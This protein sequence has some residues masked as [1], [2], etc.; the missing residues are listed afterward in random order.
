MLVATDSCEG[1]IDRDGLAEPIQ[2]AVTCPECGEETYEF[3]KYCQ[4]CGC[5]RWEAKKNAS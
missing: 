2:H 5:D 3:E 1:A 4:V